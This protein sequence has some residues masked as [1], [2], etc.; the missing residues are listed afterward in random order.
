MTAST[1]EQFYEIKVK[2]HL[3]DHWSHW[4]DNLTVIQDE[5]GNTTLSG[6]VADQAALQGLLR[7]VHNLGLELLSV[8]RIAPRIAPRITSEGETPGDGT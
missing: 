7:K 6:P 5:H 2:G 1:D 3:D 8:K 4:F